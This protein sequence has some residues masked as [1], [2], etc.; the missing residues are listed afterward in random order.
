MAFLRDPE[1]GQKPS[2]RSLYES[3]ADATFLLATQIKFET[4]KARLRTLQH[5]G[6]KAHKTQSITDEKHNIQT[7][8]SY[9]LQQKQ[10]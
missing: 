3:A 5:E 10:N 6:T 2:D 9:P 7:K 8:K 4:Q 1:I